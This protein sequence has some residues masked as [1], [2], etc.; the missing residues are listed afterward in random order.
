MTGRLFKRKAELTVTR[1]TGVTTNTGDEVTSSV[2]MR[3]V[4]MEF[5]V[6][7]TITKEPSTLECTLYNLS[8]DTRSRLEQA[9]DVDV[10]LKVAYGDNDLFGI[11]KGNL[12]NTVHSR[13]GATLVTKIEAGDGEHA[14]AAWL[15]KTYGKGTKYRTVIEDLV[16]ALGI[17]KGNVADVDNLNDSTGNGLS[18]VFPNGTSVHGHAADELGDLLSGK[19]IE[20]SIQNN[21]LQ[22]LGVGKALARGTIIP[23]LT[24]NTGLIGMPTITNKKVVTAECLI[25]PGIYPGV[26][27]DIGSEFI[28]GK[29]GDDYTTNRFKV[30]KCT[31]KGSTKGQDWTIGLEGRP[32]K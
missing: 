18:T 28:G 19:G 10:V 1:G 2:T 20:Y 23:K 25:M 17:G 4:D 29:Q 8:A 12:R 7:R 13:D 5:Q 14:Q 9:K 22:I 15:S 32:E 6:E 16:T 21:E 27:V 31:Y 3:D 30:R 24:P 11:F 26:L